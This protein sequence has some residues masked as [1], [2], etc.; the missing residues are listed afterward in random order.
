MKRTFVLFVGCVLLLAQNAGAQLDRSIIPPPG[1]APEVSFPDYELTTTANGIRVLVVQNAE[2]PTVAIRLLIDR[3]PILEGDAVGVVDIMGQVLKCGTATRTKDQIDE[4]VDLLGASLNTGGTDLYASGLS[5]NTEKLLEL[6]A[7]IA[8]HPSFPK[9]EIEKAVMQTQSG[10]KARKMEPNA[11]IEVLRKKVLYGTTHPY[12]EVESEESVGKITRDKCVAI[13]DTYF[14]PNRAIIAVVGDVE[15]NA[16]VKMVE[17]YFG[18]WKQGT[19]PEPT[20]PAVAPPAS[21]Q[22]ALVDRSSSVQSV[23]RVA[24]P[25]FLQ[26]TSPDVMPVTVMNRILGGGSADRLFMNLREKHSFTYGAYSTMGPDELVGAFTVST[27]VRNIVT[28]SALTEIYGEIARIREEDVSAAELDQAKSA[29]SGNFVASLERP[30]TI[31]SYAIE[32]ERHGLPKDHYKTYLKRL[33]AVTVPDVR[34]VARQYL[35][36]DHSLIAVVGAGKEIREKLGKFGAVTMYDE[37]GNKVV[38]KPASAVKMTVDQILFRF[39]ERTGGAKAYAALKNRTVEMSAKIQGM[40]MKITTVQKAPNKLYQE[41][42]MMGMV[43]RMGFD[44]KTGWSASPQGVKAAAGDELEA[45][46]AEGPIDF[47]KLYKTLGYAAEVTGVKD[48]KGQETY[49]VT[50]TGQSLPTLRHYFDAKDFLKIREVRTSTTPRGPMEQ[51]SDLF[52]YKAFGGV[53]IPTRVEQ[54]MMGQSFTF[55]IGKCEVNTKVEDAL[56]VKPAK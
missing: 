38:E 51:V 12:G 37:D 35:D 45:M 36:P 11:I 34:R 17:K 52:D 16:V 25:V 30:N 28:D 10:L 21:R 46:K 8:I 13:Y 48:I 23:I 24:Q 42:A 43:Q 1:P 14:K 15:K 32:I 4:Q 44:G 27:S 55:A 3:K 40:D 18:A 7:D 26:R 19:F 49:E 33:A 50:F 2:L 39:V 6:L 41:V 31:A 54:N 20:Y 56:F 53:Q 22:I 29:L 5:R 47:Y 9:D